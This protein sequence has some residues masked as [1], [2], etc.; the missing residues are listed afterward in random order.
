MDDVTIYSEYRVEIPE[1][2][3]VGHLDL[4][5]SH[6][7]KLYVYDVKTAHSFKWKK[8]FGRN[9]DPNPSVNYQLQL[10]TYALGMMKQLETKG[11]V[12]NLLM[13]LNISQ[14]RLPSGEGVLP[15]QYRR[16]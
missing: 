15:S 14:P 1:I 7:D 2:N 5:V 16:R 12:I 11:W 13:P 6:A 3:V 8:I 4:A 9:V 10:G